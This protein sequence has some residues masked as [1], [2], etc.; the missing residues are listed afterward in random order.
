MI[1]SYFIGSKRRL[2]IAPYRTLL[3]YVI[4]T[5]VLFVDSEVLHSNNVV[6]SV[7]MGYPGIWATG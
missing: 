6:S 1:A 3:E 2:R 5:A 7:S 4:E